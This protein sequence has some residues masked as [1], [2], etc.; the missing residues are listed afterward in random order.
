MRVFV[1]SPLHSYTAGRGEVEGNGETL[2]DVLADL[3]RRYPGIRFRVVDEQERI[4]PHM[5]IF[6]GGEPAVTLAEPVGA[7]RDVHILPALS[8][9]SGLEFI[10]LFPKFVTARR[11]AA[12]VLGQEMSDLKT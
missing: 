10:H 12:D 1:G 3:D 5:K 2:A 11:L 8:G 7:D 6:V 4:R 9:G